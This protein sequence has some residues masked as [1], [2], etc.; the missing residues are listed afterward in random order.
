MCLSHK[1]DPDLKLCR[2]SLS[3]QLPPATTFQYLWPICGLPSHCATDEQQ[4]KHQVTAS[5]VLPA[6]VSGRMSLQIADEVRSLLHYCSTSLANSLCRSL[7]TP[8]C[9]NRSRSCRR[10][11]RKDPTSTTQ[12]SLN[13]ETCPSKF[14]ST[15]SIPYYIVRTSY[16]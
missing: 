8:L 4:D 3:T 9:R 16:A 14:W 2:P 7:K 15:T 1:F 10:S 11:E 12:L 13:F 5:Q 6:P